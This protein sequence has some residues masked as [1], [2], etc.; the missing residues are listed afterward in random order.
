MG[1]CRRARR[2]HDPA[3]G[4]QRDL[5]RHRQAPAF[6]ADP[7]TGFDAGGVGHTTEGVVQWLGKSPRKERVRENVPSRSG[8]GRS[9]LSFLVW[10]AAP[11]PSGAGWGSRHSADSVFVFG[12]GPPPDPLC[13]S[14][15]PFQWEVSL[16]ARWFWSNAI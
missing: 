8:T 9:H 11:I 3:R 1:W 7:R 6:A 12:A 5:R 2:H 16:R 14:T 15:S 10:H 4:D 13:W